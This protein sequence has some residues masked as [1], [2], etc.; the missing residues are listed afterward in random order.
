MPSRPRIGRPPLPLTRKRIYAVTV[1][2]SLTERQMIR[3]L[4]RSTGRPITVLLR[5][6]VVALA[7]QHDIAPE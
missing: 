5:E 7:A 3:R 2:L 6:S 4:R 1:K